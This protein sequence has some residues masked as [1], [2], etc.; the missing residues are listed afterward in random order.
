MRLL[1][2]LVSW[3]LLWRI[4]TFDSELDENLTTE[5]KSIDHFAG[6]SAAY[7]FDLVI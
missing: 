3:H 2:L 4:G 7:L 5:D 1:L 6:P